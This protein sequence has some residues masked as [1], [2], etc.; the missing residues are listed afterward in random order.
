MRKWKINFFLQVFVKFLTKKKVI[1]FVLR[2]KV[3]NNTK[4][5]K[6]VCLLISPYIR[7]VGVLWDTLYHLLTSED[8]INLSSP[9]STSFCSHI[10]FLFLFYF[11]VAYFIKKFRYKKRDIYSFE[12]YSPQLNFWC[13]FLSFVV[14]LFITILWRGR[15]RLFLAKN[16]N[17]TAQ[18]LKIGY[19][20]IGKQNKI[21]LILVLEIC[22]NVVGT[23]VQHLFWRSGEKS[24]VIQ[25]GPT[26]LFLKLFSCC[27]CAP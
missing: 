2:A 26:N 6:G 25:G 9:S 21:S 17:K 22:M 5:E 19:L 15:R 3:K 27:V 4:L 14:F 1:F 13:L 8:Y 23:M 18:N 10:F 20:K 24:H 16:E 11:V 7:L 12:V